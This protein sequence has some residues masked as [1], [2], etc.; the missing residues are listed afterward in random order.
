[1]RCP[2]GA[3]GFVYLAYSLLLCLSVPFGT[4]IR[5][6]S[7]PALLCASC[8]LAYCFAFSALGSAMRYLLSLCLSCPCLLALCFAFQSIGHCKCVC[9]LELACLVCF[10]LFA[11][12]LVACLQ[13]PLPSNV[14]L[15]KDLLS[16]KRTFIL[17]TLPSNQ[18]Y[19]THSE[20][21][22]SVITCSV[23]ANTQVEHA[24]AAIQ[25]LFPSIHTPSPP[26]DLG[27]YPIPPLSSPPHHA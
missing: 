26:L 2:F 18:A 20:I 6:L 5:K 11:L 1:M 8:L 14:Q 12:C 21:T 7:S 27:A 4:S 25:L 24:A 10:N 23:D 22:C 15:V 16:L 17:L 13:I 3:L 19:Q 9:A